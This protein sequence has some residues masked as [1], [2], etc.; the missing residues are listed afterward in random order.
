LPGGAS[1]TT[2]LLELDIERYLS[3][4]SFAKISFFRSVGKDVFLG[5]GNSS[6]ISTFFI[7]RIER[8]G[9]AVRYEQQ[10]ARTLFFSAGVVAN[11]S[12]SKANGFLFDNETAPYHPRVAG[13]LALNYIDRNGNKA[14]FAVNRLGSYFQDSPLLASRPRF[15]ARTTFDLRLAREPSLQFEYFIGV[16]NL[17][18]VK[19]LNFNGFPAVG[20][21][22][23]AGVTRRF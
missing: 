2:R 15:P 21:R 12:V 7:D 14:A 18:D 6:V 8:E 11:R 20:R 17:F 16:T 10:L 13:A 9:V 3:A 22:I 23:E 5:T 19:Q 1:T 4:R